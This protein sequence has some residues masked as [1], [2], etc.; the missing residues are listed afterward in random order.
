[1]DKGPDFTIRPRLNVMSDDEI[2]SLYQGALR[3]LREVGV[4]ALSPEGIGLARKVGAMVE[5]DGLVRFPPEVVER[6]IAS[7]PKR[8]TIH[9][10]DGN[11]AMVLGGG[12]T[13]G[14]NTYYGTGSDLKHTYD[15]FTGDLRLTTAQDIANMARVVDFLS[16]S[17]FLMSY[18]IPSDV[19]LERVYPTE[20]LMMVRNSTKPIAFTSSNGEEARHII[21]M[22]ALVAGGLDRLRERPFVLG[23]AQPTSPLQHSADALGKLLTCAEMGIPACYPPGMIPGATAPTTMA[24]AMTQSLAEALSALVLHQTKSPGTPIV[25]CGAHGCMDMRTAINVYAAPERLTTQAALAAVYQRFGIPTWGFGGCTDALVLDA[26]AGAEFA[27]LALW[28]SL[29]GINLAHDVGYLGSGMVGDLRAIVHNNEINRYVRHVLVRGVPVTDET[30]AF[31]AMER[32]GS[33]G[34][35]LSDEHTRDHFRTELWPPGLSNRLS[36]E[37]WQKAGKETMEGRLTGAVREI[38]SSHEPKP[39]DPE[40]ARALDEMAGSC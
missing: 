25:L 17:E 37:G 23:Y 22:A 40:I 3:V 32:V 8:V 20:F 27:T 24:G 21:E 28:A 2:D 5:D 7:A 10:R 31:D 15:P 14:Q 18:G 1:M 6:A 35:Y 4:K 39:L 36:L 34:A 12:N 29:T 19:P 26:Q 16:D 38:L 30:M 13:G 11:E 33:G 9:D